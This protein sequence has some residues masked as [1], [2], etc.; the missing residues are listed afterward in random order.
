MTSCTHRIVAAGLLIAGVVAAN[1]AFIGL[2]STFEYPD[3]LQQPAGEIIAR[4]D[5]TR[6]STMAWFVMLAAG[7]ALLGPAAVLLARLGRGRAGRWS[8]FVGVGAALVQV[9]GL[10]RWF[11]LVP[12][13]AD[14]ATDPTA[15]LAARAHAVADFESANRVLGTVVG[16]TLGY[17]LTAIWTI[18]L[19]A[20]IVPATL[21][22]FRAWG[23]ASAGLIFSGV[24]VPL[25][26]PGAD[27]ANFAGYVLWSLWLVALAVRVVQNR[28][29]TAEAVPGNITSPTTTQT[30]PADLVNS[31][32]PDEVDALRPAITR[33]RT[34]R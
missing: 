22:W 26:V 24:L 21:R 18:L 19:L 20:A 13:Y 30:A 7:A 23:V 6:S 3:I 2:G 16:E 29:A 27:T 34:P 8:A 4:F 15:S 11:L 32:S 9:V 5:E 12:G 17:T 31:S 25:D 14:R 1:A 10:S 33:R 28:I